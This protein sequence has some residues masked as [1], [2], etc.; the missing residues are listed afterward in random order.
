MWQRAAGGA[1][2]IAQRER[3][4]QNER[5]RLHDEAMR[6][7]MKATTHLSDHNETDNSLTATLRN[8]LVAM[9]NDVDTLAAS[10]DALRGD[11][12]RV[13]A[14]RD[15]AL[16]ELS[17]LKATT[18][19]TTTTT[20]TITGQPHGTLVGDDIDDH[21][22]H[23]GEKNGNAEDGE[24]TVCGDGDE[25]NNDDENDGD[26]DDDDDGGDGD[27]DVS[28]DALARDADAYW[29]DQERLLAS[30]SRWCECSCD[31]QFCFCCFFLRMPS[32]RSV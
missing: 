28:V 30:R 17:A 15:A 14:E 20:T 24:T 6:T 12:S 9:C 16:S 5:W 26:D 27:D 3:T 18:T 21:D 7:R 23:G 25:I 2:K 1:S 8:E 4:E 19:T 32:L 22:D 29:R 11:V 10:R 31:V 13:S